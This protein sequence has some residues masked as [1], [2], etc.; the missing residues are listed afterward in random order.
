MQ[1]P[2]ASLPATAGEV[3]AE[4]D[5]EDGDYEPVLEVLAEEQAILV[6]GAKGSGK[7]TLLLWLMAQRQNA[8][9][10]D[11][12]GSPDKWPNCHIVGSGRQFD[13]IGRALT[14]IEKLMTTRYAEI[15]DGRVQEGQHEK[16]TLFVDE[17]RAIVQNV[18]NARQIIA[19]LLT[20]ARKANIDIVLVSHSKNVKA[21]GLDGEG[22]LR[23]GFAFVHISVVRG[24]RHAQVVFGMDEE[25]AVPVTL[26]G[27]FSR[28]V[29]P[30]YPVNRAPQILRLTEGH[31]DPDDQPAMAQGLAT[32]W[33]F[34][35]IEEINH[36]LHRAAH[37]RSEHGRE[38]R[39]SICTETY[40]YD[41]GDAYQRLKYILDLAEASP[42]DFFDIPQQINWLMSQSATA[43]L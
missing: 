26:P 1:R 16:V 31:S 27:Q 15:G 13:H 7:T 5:I 33:G 43:D 29:R 22:D 21:L 3:I 42:V 40:G 41:G 37:N 25:T 8:V 19:T 35:S 38:L 36:I 11:P 32:R 23:E 24:Q 34:M 6:H 17:Y 14:T 30:A 20:E 10:I 39:R 18:P 12:H 28:A 9:I 4:D 2:A